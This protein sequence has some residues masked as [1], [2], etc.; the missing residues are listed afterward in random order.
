MSSGD[1]CAA[2][3]L[4][5][6]ESLAAVSTVLQLS[7]LVVNESNSLLSNLDSTEADA[8]AALQRTTQQ[9]ARATALNQV[10]QSISRSH[11]YRPL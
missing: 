5:A 4:V 11:F 6:N 9:H 3:Q 10:N 2:E 8:L 7:Q 1:F